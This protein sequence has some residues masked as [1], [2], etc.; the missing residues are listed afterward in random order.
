[1]AKVT[2]VKAHAPSRIRFVLVDAELGEG[3]IGQI[4]QAIQNALRSPVLAPARKISVAIPSVAEQLLEEAETPDDPDEADAG[5]SDNLA[6]KVRSPRK[7]P[8]TPDIV[9]I[10]M[11]ADPSLRSFATGKD[12]KSQAKKYLISAAWLKEHR[13]INSVTADH[14]YTCFRSMGWSTNISDFWAPL[15]QLKAKRYFTQN[16]GGEYVINHVGLDYV[17]RLGGANEA[18]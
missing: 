11:N 18:S 7:P 4:T 17:V 2:S 9:A 13:S 8:P 16:E 1:M 6:S 5:V 15:R 12:A 10:D 14:I 3:D